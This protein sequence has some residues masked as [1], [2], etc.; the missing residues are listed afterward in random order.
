MN[1]NIAVLFLLIS[2]ISSC[3]KYKVKHHGC[4]CEPVNEKF[5]GGYVFM[6]N[7][8]SPNGDGNN[9]C[10]VITNKGATGI[11][12]MV[13]NSLG[14]VLYDNSN[15]ENANNGNYFWC[16]EKEPSKNLTET[17]LYPY[18]LSYTTPSGER[19]KVCGKITLF[20]LSNHRGKDYLEVNCIDHLNSCVFGTQWISDT[21]PFLP[22]DPNSNEI[23]FGE[24]K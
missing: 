14:K 17:N 15:L 1:K 13:K 6:P 12:L 2:I 11:R 24:C 16:G 20:R 19:K 18:E 4:E 7:A 23:L 8:F 9:D 22:V 21:L 3:G 10:L 5:N